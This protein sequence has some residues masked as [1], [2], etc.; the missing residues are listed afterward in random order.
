MNRALRSPLSVAL[1]LLGTQA[2][3]GE[4]QT[5]RVAVRICNYAEVRAEVLDRAKA[6]ATRIFRQAGVEVVWIDHDLS[7][8]A[9]HIPVALDEKVFTLKLLPASMAA[10]LPRPANAFGFAVHLD[11]YVFVDRVNDV[12][13]DIGLPLPLILGHIMAHELGT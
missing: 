12:T 4:V 7:R 11:A 1:F 5:V 6:E 3:A 13:R 10:R 9:D 2:G 8:R